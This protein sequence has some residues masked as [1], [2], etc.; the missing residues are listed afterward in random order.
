MKVLAINCG[1]ST[2]KFQIFELDGSTPLGRERR[3]AHG[4]VERI[5]HPG[6]VNLTIEEGKS[7]QEITKIADHGIA[8]ER[9]LN[10][11]EIPWLHGKGW[12]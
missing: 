10:W 7:F 5:G 2:L 4:L 6:V 12:N 11:H 3:L 9:M 1:S 8:T